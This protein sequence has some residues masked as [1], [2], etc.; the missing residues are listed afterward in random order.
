MI[1]FKLINKD[2]KG[3]IFG[4][5]TPTDSSPIVIMGGF[6]SSA[7]IYRGMSRSLNQLTGRS[8]YVV[9]TRSSEWLLSVWMAGWTILLDRL[10]RTVKQALASTG[11]T[12]LTLIGH[13]MGGVIS[14]LYLNPEPLRGRTFNGLERVEHLISLGSPHYN[15][16]NWQRGGPLSR[17]VEEHSPGAFFSPAIRYTSVA[18]RWIK[19]ERSGNRQAAWVYDRYA[20]IG[21]EGDDWGDGII[22]LRSALLAGSKQITLQGVCHYSPT[23]TPWY[24]TGEVIPLWWQAS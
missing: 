11:E 6:L 20:E 21:G 24:G 18:G 23:G 16:G 9:K 15:L 2:H 22:P 7:V 3:R 4:K 14:R 1:K 12:G 8:V 5:M 19:G 10:D 17:W 13:S